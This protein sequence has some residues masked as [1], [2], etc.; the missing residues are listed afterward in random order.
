MFEHE[1]CVPVVVAARPRVDIGAL[2]ALRRLLT[3]ASGGKPTGGLAPAAAAAAAG[4]SSDQNR[5]EVHAT[6][7]RRPPPEDAGAG[8]VRHP[9]LFA[10]PPAAS[11][12]GAAVWRALPEGTR[13]TLTGLLARLLTEH[14]ADARRGGGRHDR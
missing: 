4:D 12:A 2:C 7:P 3:E 1:T 5:G 9:D 6:P 14:R 13:R 11:G 8:R 10:P